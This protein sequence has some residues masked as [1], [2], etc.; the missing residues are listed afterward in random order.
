MLSE[1]KE[2][3]LAEKNIAGGWRLGVDVLAWRNAYR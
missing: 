3:G 2:V 1:L